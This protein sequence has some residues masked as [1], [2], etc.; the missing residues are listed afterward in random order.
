MKKAI[1]FLLPWLFLISCNSNWDK[2]PS[3]TLSYQI[4]ENPYLE[5]K[6][7]KNDLE[8]AVDENM[9]RLATGPNR[10]V[11]LGENLYTQTVYAFDSVSGTV[12]WQQDFANP[13]ISA[14]HDSTFYTTNLNNIYAYNLQNGELLW[15]HSLP[16]NGRLLFLTFYKDKL[17]T[18]SANGTFLTLDS[19]GNVLSSKGPLIYPSPI[20]VEDTITYANKNSLI[21]MDAKTEKILWESA[22]D[23]GYFTGVLF[24]GNTIYVRQGSAIQPGKVYAINK[25]NGETLWENSENAISNVCAL[26]SNLY[27]LTWDGYLVGLDLASGQ[28]TVR[29]EFSPRLFILGGGGSSVHGYYLAADPENNLLFVSLGDSYQLFALQVKSK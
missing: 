25:S 15:N 18:Y 29:I 5:V 17:F 16:Y 2:K 4:V 6:W 13:D 26:G 21:A 19:R 20:V 1:I 7:L 8:I 24:S 23:G 14:I 28:E 22:I 9:P 3:P 10:V 11:A 27:F 12:V